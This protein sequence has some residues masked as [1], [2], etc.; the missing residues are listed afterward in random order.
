M[1]NEET[2][3]WLSFSISS[4]HS[5]PY[6]SCFKYNKCEQPYVHIEQRE[7]SVN[8]GKVLENKMFF[9]R[10]ISTKALLI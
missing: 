7:I 5:T 4:F 9:I 1:L 6:C 3:A 10:L 8:Y 2:Q